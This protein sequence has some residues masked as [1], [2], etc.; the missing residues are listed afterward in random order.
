MMR[1]RHLIAGSVWRGGI[2]LALVAFQAGFL[3]GCVDQ[4]KEV[5]TYREVLEDYRPKPKALRPGKPD[6]GTSFGAGQ[7]R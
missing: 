4:A 1:W 5:R 6:F 2:A 7:C 3:A